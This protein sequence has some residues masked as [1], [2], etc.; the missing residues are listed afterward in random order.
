[1]VCSLNY[2]FSFKALV[3]LIAPWINRDFKKQERE[4]EMTTA[5]V[6]N[7]IPIL[8]FAL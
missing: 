3:V 7:I 5:V 8:V 2:V 6:K 1:M 4:T